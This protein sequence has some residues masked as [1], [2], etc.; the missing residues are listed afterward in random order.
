MKVLASLIFPILVLAVGFVT[1]IIP[2][3]LLGLLDWHEGAEIIVPFLWAIGY[4]KQ[5]ARNYGDVNWITLCVAIFGELWLAS[6]F[7][8]WAT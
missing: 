3:L 6:R 5:R 2:G 7:G 1:G 4:V 8:C